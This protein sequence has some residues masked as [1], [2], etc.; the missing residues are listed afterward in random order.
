MEFF[1]LEQL[2]V[3]GFDTLEGARR[4]AL[5]STVGMYNL[6]G[7]LS[8]H[9][10][11]I[12]ERGGK[13]IETIIGGF[14]ESE[15]NMMRGCQSSE[16]TGETENNGTEYMGPYRAEL[17]HLNMPNVSRVYNLEV[18]LKAAADLTRGTFKLN[19]QLSDRY[20]KIFDKNGDL[21]ETIIGGFTES[22][23]NA[24]KE[25]QAKEKAENEKAEVKSVVSFSWKH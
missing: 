24:I 5:N 22:E 17:I 11:K 10:A 1:R 9:E 12:F 18:A 25:R 20:V 13:Y 7:V 16:K 19:G 23:Y 3:T 21:V 6:N 4:Y 15:Y 14:P 2:I 8:D